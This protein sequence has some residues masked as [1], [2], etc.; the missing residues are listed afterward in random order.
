MKETIGEDGYIIIYLKNKR[1]FNNQ[2]LINTK[3]LHHTFISYRRGEA[4]LKENHLYNLKR[5]GKDDYISVLLYMSI[6]ITIYKV[7]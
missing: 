4:A 5:T 2:L 6:I 7:G 1:V 3:K